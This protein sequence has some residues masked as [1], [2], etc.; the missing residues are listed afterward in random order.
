M[1]VGGTGA[2]YVGDGI[3]CLR[4]EWRQ[5][6]VPHEHYVVICLSESHVYWTSFAVP[7]ELSCKG[8]NL[9]QCH[10]AADADVATGATCMAGKPAINRTRCASRR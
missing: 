8:Y 2:E 4:I 9:T 1:N 7:T 5:L 6:Q 10:H 3:Q